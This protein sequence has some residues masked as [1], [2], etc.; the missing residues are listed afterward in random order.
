MASLTNISFSAQGFVNNPVGV[1]SNNMN[2][3]TDWVIAV[4]G[5]WEA[6]LTSAV[7]DTNGTPATL[8]WETL[9]SAPVHN[10]AIASAALEFGDIIAGSH[11]IASSTIV[12]DDD[13]EAN[14]SGSGWKKCA[15]PS[16]F[17]F[18]GSTEPG[19]ETSY[20]ILVEWDVAGQW[21]HFNVTVNV[22][23]SG[24][25]NY[26]YWSGSLDTQYLSLEET[27]AL[28]D[29]V[30]I[31]VYV[32]AVNGGGGI[33]DPGFDQ[34]SP[35]AKAVNV[36]PEDEED[37]VD[38]RE[39]LTFRWSTT[40]GYYGA[41]Y[42]YLGSEFGGDL[43]FI[44]E[45]PAGTLEYEHDGAG[46]VV[47]GNVWRV[48]LTGYGGITVE[49]DEW[50]FDISVSTVLYPPTNPTP[51][52]AAENV[53]LNTELLE[54]EHVVPEGGFGTA[55][56]Y[57]VYFNGLF[58]GNTGIKQYP[59]PRQH[60][61]YGATYTWKV[62]AKNGMSTNSSAL[63]SFTT[64]ALATSPV[65]GADGTRVKRLVAAADDKIWIESV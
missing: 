40:P 51:A 18:N 17:R 56:T 64:A 52:D 59:M 1:M 33:G 14:I 11:V 34:W 50:T 21:D 44:A 48:D 13:E 58:L 5:D 60:L 23:T 43:E 16:N 32:R 65:G 47:S 26:T 39:G 12:D 2:F 9:T 45:I 29:A 20:P 37:N 41:S 24:G 30:R 54:W 3:T 36:Y 25:E 35:V 19:G 28:L 55:P 49:G 57:D 38:V 6:P 63:W 31:T 27:E 46:L 22:L 42:L 15:T 4:Q 53:P 7:F 8:G 10:K 62:I 61:A